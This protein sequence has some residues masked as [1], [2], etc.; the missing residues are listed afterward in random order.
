MFGNLSHLALQQYWWVIISLL[1]SFLVF[2]MFVQGGQT[3]IFTL[4]KKPIQKT[5]MVNALG[6]KWEFTFTTLVTFGGAF[7]AS[8]PLFYATSFGGAYWVWM[9]ILFCFIIQAIAYEFRSKPDNFLGQK[10]YDIFLFVNGALGTILIGTAVGTFFN[11]ANFTVSDMNISTWE[12]P[13]HGLEAV[14]NWHNVALGLTVFFLARLLGIMYFIR[15]IED[16][17]LTARARRHMLFNA[18]PFLVLFL[19]FAIRLLVMKGFAYDPETLVVSR[20]PFKYL[21]NLLSMPLVLILFLAGVVLVLFS[22]YKTV[23]SGSNRGFYSGAAGTILVVFSL[24]LVAGLNKTCYYPSLYDLQSSL[25]IEN[26]SSS[27]YTLKAMSFVSLLSPLVIGY[28]YLAWS[29]IN[30]KKIDPEEMEN[31]SHVY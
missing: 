24:F 28:I 6:R 27:Q 19:A 9:A 11:G 23:F 15:N 12:N 17:D 20:E 13:A 5:M 8:F 16:E 21:H 25:N 14:L 26:S 30:K 3:L 22:I 29:A 2:L 7:F 18:I 31:E 1:A 10:T 4:G